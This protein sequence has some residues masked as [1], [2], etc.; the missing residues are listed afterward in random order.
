VKLELNKE[1][2]Q[3]NKERQ[4]L[5]DLYKKYI[6]LHRNELM[7]LV[8]DDDNEQSQIAK[9]VLKYLWLNPRLLLIF[10]D[11]IGQGTKDL[12]TALERLFYEGRHVNFTVLVAT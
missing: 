8:K 3:S 4:T 12:N 10:D 7:L 1:I 5:I 11:C 2:A 6:Q 9:V